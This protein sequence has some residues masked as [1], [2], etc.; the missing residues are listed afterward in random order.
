[1]CR[2]CNS[3]AKRT[4]DDSRAAHPTLEY[5]GPEPIQ[6]DGKEYLI[7]VDTFSGYWE[8]DELSQTAAQAV[9]GKTKQHLARY[10][11]PDRVYTDNGTQFDCAEYTRFAE[12]WNFEHHTSSPYHVQSNGLVEA[13]VKTAKTLQKKATKAG[14]DLNG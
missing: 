11:I 9:I 3:P 14:Q 8:N 5:C 7:T 10:G 4:A 1:L 2:V 13:A 6:R 12:T